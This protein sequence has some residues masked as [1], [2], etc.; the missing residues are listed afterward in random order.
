MLTTPLREASTNGHIDAVLL[1]INPNGINYN[2]DKL[3]NML[4]PLHTASRNGHLNVVKL[5]VERGAN[6]NIRSGY[7][8][9]RPLSYAYEY[10]YDEIAT[11]LLS[12]NVDSDMKDK[13]GICC[14]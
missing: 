5:L 13:Y 14:W 11:Y 2:K 3:Y 7:D 1:G 8:L 12:H 4:T 10:S 6:V 9:R